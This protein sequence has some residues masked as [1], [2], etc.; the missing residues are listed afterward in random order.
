MALGSKGTIAVSVDNTRRSHAAHE[1]VPFQTKDSAS[2]SASLVSGRD[3]GRWEGGGAGAS[4][5]SGGGGG[6]TR[7]SSGDG[8]GRGSTVN[9]TQ[10]VKKNPMIPPLRLSA[11]V[12]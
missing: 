1:F 4:N 7:A 9:H 10:F 3:G 5:G 2:K 6:G 12:C 11:L 8:G